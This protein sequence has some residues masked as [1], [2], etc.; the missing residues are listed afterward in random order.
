[1]EAVAIIAEF[2][3]FHTGH[4]YLIRQ[5]SGAYLGPMRPSSSS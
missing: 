4:A 2:N 5:G 3:P 1:M